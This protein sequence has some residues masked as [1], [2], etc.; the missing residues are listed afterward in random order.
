M[1]NPVI[2]AVVKYV[3]K[4]GSGKRGN[5]GG[6]SMTR[7]TSTSTQSS[8]P[9]PILAFNA[10]D[11]KHLLLE[12]QQMIYPSPP[13]AP[14]PR[15]SASRNGIPSPVHSRAHSF[16]QQ[17]TTSRTP[18]VEP[19]GCCGLVSA[20]V[21]E[22]MRPCAYCPVAQRTL[23]LLAAHS[24]KLPSTHRPKRDRINQ[25]DSFASRFATQH[26]AFGYNDFMYFCLEERVACGVCADAAPAAS[27]RDSPEQKC[28]FMLQ[29]LQYMYTRSHDDGSQSELD[30]NSTSGFQSV[31]KLRECIGE[32]GPGALKVVAALSQHRKVVKAEDHCAE[33][34]SMYPD[35]IKVQNV[36][37]SSYFHFAPAVLMN[38]PETSAFRLS[39]GSISS[40]QIRTIGS[41][42]P[43]PLLPLLCSSTTPP[44]LE[45]LY[46]IAVLPKTEITTAR[47]AV[48][49]SVG[50]MK[51]ILPISVPCSI[52]LLRT[53]LWPHGATLVSRSGRRIVRTVSDDSHLPQ[54]FAHRASC[55]DLLPDNPMERT[56]SYC[57][58]TTTFMSSG[59]DAVNKGLHHSYALIP[60]E[61]FEEFSGISFID[62]SND[63][64]AC[65]G[66]SR[67]SQS[68]DSAGGFYMIQFRDCSQV[69]SEVHS[70]LS[71]GEAPVAV[72]QV[73]SPNGLSGQEGGMLTDM[74]LFQQILIAHRDGILGSGD[75]SSSELPI[76]STVCRWRACLAEACKESATKYLCRYHYDIKLFLDSAGGKNTGKDKPTGKESS[77]YLPKKSA[78][79]LPNDTSDRDLKI[80]RGSSTLIQ[81]LWDGKLRNT[82][83]SFTHKTCIDLGPRKRL[84]AALKAQA[85]SASSDHWRVVSMWERPTWSRWRHEGE[86]DRVCGAIGSAVDLVS[87]T[88]RIERQMIEE[89]K[90]LS[91]MKVFPSSE[92]V[93]IRREVKACKENA[94]AASTDI[95]L[96]SETAEASLESELV[97]AEKKLD[98]IR[99]RRL[100]E[101]AARVAHK[102]KVAR[103]RQLEE[104]QSR[105]PLNFKNQ[106]RY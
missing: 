99:R 3:A 15:S 68:T 13:H 11:M 60:S 61:F 36:Y 37:N 8:A 89:L 52:E 45:R 81:E 22:W 16:H 69:D 83:A 47:G 73:D 75:G 44:P 87:M 43:H 5:D 55:L 24:D 62:A 35:V 28:L 7:P 50:D 82:V 32:G 104:S 95:G 94:A 58:D 96:S 19:L 66:A 92:L 30:G 9:S 34:I 10:E 12:C 54:H 27:S 64:A 39:E 42:C 56:W 90:L 4:G 77:K 29:Y 91:N 6:N 65:D 98:L 31:R 88:Q 63:G 101:E 20:S 105:D 48:P 25:F 14:R 74:D 78:F 93:I 86:F 70:D 49:M 97:L 40:D 33:M 46:V 23:T 59:N 102:K 17:D 106:S 72:L 26:T 18:R 103:S 57:P 2:C 53:Y 41:Q 51:V 38:L 71:T 100:E 85:K 67:R 80:I 21:I 76:L 1:A 79:N 84:E